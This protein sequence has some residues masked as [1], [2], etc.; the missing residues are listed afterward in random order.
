MKIHHEPL[1]RFQEDFSYSPL[2]Q[3]LNNYLLHN[4]KKPSHT[5]LALRSSIAPLTVSAIFFS[6]VFFYSYTRLAK[7]IARFSLFFMLVHIRGHFLLLLTSAKL[8]LKPSL[9]HHHSS[10][11]THKA[12]FFLLLPFQTPKH[13]KTYKTFF[14]SS[15]RKQSAC[16]FNS[17][18]LY[19]FY[20]ICLRLFSACRISISL[21]RLW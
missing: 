9:S 10:S 13:P 5:K 12:H 8:R 11:P 14:P 17:D 3:L 21:Q 6:S 15:F 2:S 20:F 7:K 16:C 19:I 4:R 1:E 18:L